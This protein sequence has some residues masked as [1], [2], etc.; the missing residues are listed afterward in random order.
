MT[1][2]FKN[3]A[4]FSL[5]LLTFTQVSTAN[6]FYPLEDGSLW[7]Y[8]DSNNKTIL[9]KLFEKKSL[10]II[11]QFYLKYPRGK[12]SYLQSILA[13]LT[14]GY[15]DSLWMVKGLIRELCS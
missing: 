7:K 6:D 8:Q 3:R 11:L 12:Q 10:V 14:K 15:L 9:K 13:L 4:I 1:F 5:L 2:L